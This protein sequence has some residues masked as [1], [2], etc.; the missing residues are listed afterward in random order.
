MGNG[1]MEEMMTP[2]V[3][4]TIGFLLHLLLNQEVPSSNEG[5]ALCTC[6]LWPSLV[7]ISL[8]ADCRNK[9]IKGTRL[10]LSQGLRSFLKQLESQPQSLRY[11][12]LAALCVCRRVP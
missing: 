2:Q 7:F 6:P 4:S 3:P 8:E 9:E 10:Q 11:S 12:E 1:A 5:K